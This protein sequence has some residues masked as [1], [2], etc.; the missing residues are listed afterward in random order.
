MDLALNEEGQILVSKEVPEG[1]DYNFPVIPCLG[2]DD[3]P[4]IIRKRFRKRSTVAVRHG[5]LSVSRT[6]RLSSQLIRGWT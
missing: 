2:S 1:R 6:I 5:N 4:G 3:R